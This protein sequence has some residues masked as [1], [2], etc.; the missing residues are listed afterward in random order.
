MYED[1]EEHVERFRQYLRTLQFEYEVRYI[2]AVKAFI[3]E[4]LERELVQKLVETNGKHLRFKEYVEYV[5]VRLSEES[6]N[7]LLEW[8]PPPVGWTVRAHHM[9]IFQGDSGHMLEGTPWRL[10]D[11]VK[12]RIIAVGFDQMAIAVEVDAGEIPCKNKIRHVTV[13]HVPNAKPV[14]SNFIRNWVDVAD[15]LKEQTKIQYPD[16]KKRREVFKLSTNFPESGNC[17]L[18]G[19]ISEF[20]LTG[21]DNKKTV[22]SH[23]R[24]S[25]G[26]LIKKI[27]PHL[28][29]REIG[30]GVELV[31]N[32]MSENHN[33]E[34]EKIEEFI[35][36][37]FPSG[38]LQ[39]QKIEITKS[40]TVKKEEETQ[41]TNVE[42]RKTVE[43]TTEEIKP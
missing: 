27:H 33:L 10:G 29:G 42:I 30:R 14:A 38:L 39:Q 40:E 35:K 43:K 3:H 28:E 37:L 12:L 24:V 1:R 21:I 31:K 18:Y 17:V 9:S 8:I 34:Q 6:R 5:G 4:D 25:Y 36:N 2:L 15:L 32:W 20:R 22:L 26:D 13:A 23:P 11:E 41:T 19:M 16:V 7:L